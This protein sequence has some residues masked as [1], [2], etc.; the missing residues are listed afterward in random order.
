MGDRD[1]FGPAADQLGAPLAWKNGFGQTSRWFSFQ[2]IWPRMVHSPHQHLAVE[3]YHHLDCQV[4]IKKSRVLKHLC[5]SAGLW[6]MLKS[7]WCAVTI[8]AVPAGFWTF[9]LSSATLRRAAH[10]QIRVGLISRFPLFQCSETSH[11]DSNASAI[12][13]GK[14]PM[15]CSVHTNFLAY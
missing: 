15:C 10:P 4:L 1:L 13:A 7:I 8:S 9:K 11:L 5:Y 6:L 3:L 12:Y 14:N 2:I